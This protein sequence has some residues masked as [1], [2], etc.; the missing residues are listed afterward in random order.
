M[1]HQI[2]ESRAGEASGLHAIGLDDGGHLVGGADPRRE[3]QARA[4]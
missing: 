3:G 1:G 2:S 4:P